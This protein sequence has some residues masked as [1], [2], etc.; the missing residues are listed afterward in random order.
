[1]QQ[2]EHTR[3]DEPGQMQST[4]RQT[5]PQPDT[6]DASKQTSS[7]SPEDHHHGSSGIIGIIILVLAIVLGGLY[8][9]STNTEAPTIEEPTPVEEPETDP[10]VEDMM[11]LE[12]STEL[13]AIERDLENTDLDAIDADLDDL[14]AEFETQLEAEM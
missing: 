13:N 4:P 3:T 14:E 5:P 11:Q 2:E 12:S 6:V 10:V 9:W 7:T 1:M 8:F